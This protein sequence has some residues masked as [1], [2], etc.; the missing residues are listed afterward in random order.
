MSYSFSLAHNNICVC[1]CVCVDA[2]IVF[3]SFS[4]TIGCPKA[5]PSLPHPPSMLCGLARCRGSAHSQQNVLMSV[6]QFQ[7]GPQVGR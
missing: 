1:V 2:G 6:H 5:Q 4:A 7:V 3:V